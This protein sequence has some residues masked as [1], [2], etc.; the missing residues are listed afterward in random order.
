MTSS[1]CPPDGFR[2]HAGSTTTYGGRY[3]GVVSI[4]VPD[5]VFAITSEGSNSSRFPWLGVSFGRRGFLSRLRR[6][7]RNRENHGRKDRKGCGRVLHSRVWCDMDTTCSATDS[8][9]NG[10][11]R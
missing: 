6:H 3:F 2:S 1:L 7:K 9:K 8:E 4:W 5:N 11:Y 10:G